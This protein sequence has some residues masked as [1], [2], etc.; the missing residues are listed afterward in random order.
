MLIYITN[1]GLPNAPTSRT[2]K[3][4]VKKISQKLNTAKP[5]G[6]DR[7]VSGLASADFKSITFYPRGKESAAA[8]L[9]R[10]TH[11]RCVDHHRTDEALT[12]NIALTIEDKYVFG[13]GMDYNGLY[14]QLD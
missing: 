9:L 5:G 11:D 7:I 13:F 8:V 3:I 1:R 10:K 4:A 2:R 6:H 12:D 14:R